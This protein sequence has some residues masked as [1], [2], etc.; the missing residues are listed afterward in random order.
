M[1]KKG[2]ISLLGMSSTVLTHEN[3]GCLEPK[4]VQGFR[5]ID[6]KSSVLDRLNVRL[7]FYTEVE[8]P[9]RYFGNI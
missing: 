7:L 1:G 5:G 8:M 3:G 2:E 9:S 6:T 4:G